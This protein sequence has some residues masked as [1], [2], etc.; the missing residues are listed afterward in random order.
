MVGNEQGNQN[1]EL[2]RGMGNG[3][4]RKEKGSMRNK[5]FLGE[6]IA[7]AWLLLCLLFLLGLSLLEGQ[8][9]SLIIIRF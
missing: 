3:E 2:E 6:W 8:R 9:R 1:E 7:N 4:E 5:H